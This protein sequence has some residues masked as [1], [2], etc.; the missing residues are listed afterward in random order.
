MSE[1]AMGGPFFWN[2]LGI[3]PVPSFRLDVFVCRDL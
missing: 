3:K 2:G 1:E